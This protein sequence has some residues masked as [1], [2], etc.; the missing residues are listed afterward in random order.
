[1]CLFSF[2][3]EAMPAR[4]QR[5][6]VPNCKCKRVGV[7]HF[8]F[9]TCNSYI[10]RRNGDMFL[11]QR[12]LVKQCSEKVPEPTFSTNHRHCRILL[13]FV[14]NR[15]TT[16]SRF[17]LLHG[18]S[19]VFSSQVFAE[20]ECHDDPESEGGESDC[21]RVMV[22]RSP[23]RRPDIGAGDV[24]EMGETIDDGEGHRPL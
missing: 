18:K 1:M 6:C 21:I 3:T 10:L 24:T 20:D 15:F 13:L 14:Q 19:H 2:L 11:E 16:I 9:H 8:I 23:H 7:R 5:R 22:R 17:L 12:S 4:M